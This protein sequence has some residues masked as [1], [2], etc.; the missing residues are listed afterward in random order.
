MGG[1]LSSAP[2]GKAPVF[3][4]YAM[5][6]PD[7]P[8]LDRIQIVK[9]WL[10][11][12]GKAQERIY[13]VAVSGGRRIDAN[14]RCKTPVGNTVDIPNATY[15]N[16]IGAG[17]LSAY[18]KD[19]AFDASQGAFYYI[20]VIRSRRLVGRPMTRSGSASRCPTTSQ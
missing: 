11:K 13:D 17:M 5:R 3:M 14:G 20:R 4:V 16:T 15:S 19:P 1:D 6:D 18:W 2:V 7:G 10:G 12:D 9:G 8:N